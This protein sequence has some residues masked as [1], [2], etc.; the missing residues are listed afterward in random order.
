M[1]VVVLYLQIK[2]NLFLKNNFF[3]KLLKYFLMKGLKRPDD[4]YPRTTRAGEI[5]INIW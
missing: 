1:F 3:P 2:K 5:F 4:S